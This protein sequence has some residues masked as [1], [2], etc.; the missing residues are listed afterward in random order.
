[1]V[2][3]ISKNFYFYN[4]K[5]K[6]FQ[7]LRYYHYTFPCKALQLHHMLQYL[8]IS[9]YYHNILY[10]SIYIPSLRTGIFPINT[11]CSRSRR[12]LV[13]QQI[14]HHSNIISYPHFLYILPTNQSSLSPHSPSIHSHH[15]SQ[16]KLT[17]SHSF[18][19]NTP[20]PLTSHTTQ[21]I[22]ITQSPIT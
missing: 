8:S 2:T 1:M 7:I 12:V 22:P 20:N 19:K 15:T 4:I 9:I 16:P 21:T 17:H 3:A 14:K 6:K 18:S 13:I 11:H 5:F 10:N